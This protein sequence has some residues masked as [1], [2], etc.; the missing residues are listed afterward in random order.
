MLRD[1]RG[2]AVRTASNRA[3]SIVAR[4][5]RIGP[6]LEDSVP[7]A[8]LTTA[9]GGSIAL[10]PTDPARAR[11]LDKYLYVDL[12]LADGRR[13]APRFGE[14]VHVRFAH[15][16]EPI[17]HRMMRSLRQVFLKHFSV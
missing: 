13:P 1:T 7:N 10:D 15:A 3:E 6:Q 14:R 2:I 4:L 12:V 5:D 16:D 11:T 9:G 17:A 8:V